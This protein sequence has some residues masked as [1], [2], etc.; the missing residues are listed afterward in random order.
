LGEF[1]QTEF[2]KRGCA[3]ENEHGHAFAAVCGKA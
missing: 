2:G 1:M 3:T